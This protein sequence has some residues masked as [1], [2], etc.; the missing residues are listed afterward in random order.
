MNKLNLTRLLVIIVIILFAIW[1]MSCE[2]D[3]VE[4]VKPYYCIEARIKAANY[5]VDKFCVLIDDHKRGASIEFSTWRNGMNILGV[6]QYVHNKV[7]N[8]NDCK[9]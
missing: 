7:V 2:D 6:D 3:K 1:L 4:P 9:K 5:T 8:C